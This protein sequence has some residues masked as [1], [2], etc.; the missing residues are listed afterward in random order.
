ME[1]LLQL[2]LNSK[3]LSNQIYSQ[4][5]PLPPAG[6]EAVKPLAPPPPFDMRKSGNVVE[7]MKGQVCG[8]VRGKMGGVGDEALTCNVIYSCRCRSEVG[9]E[10]DRSE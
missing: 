2:T 1:K 3:F 5:P 8:C 4:F 7:L 10:R 9:R 6:S